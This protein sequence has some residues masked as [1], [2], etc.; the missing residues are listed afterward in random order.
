[1]VTKFLDEFTPWMVDMITNHSNIILMGSFNIHIGDED[2]AEGI[3][4]LDTIE[5]LSLEQWVDKP[6]HRSDNILDL[7]VSGAE[8][9]TKPVRCATGGLISD[10]LTIHFTLELKQSIF[11]RKK[12]ITYHKLK[13][14]N[15]FALDLAEMD[16]KGDDLDSI[17]SEFETKLKQTLDKHAPEVTKKITERKRQPWFDDNIKNLK[18][19]MHRR[20]KVWRKYK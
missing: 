4:F 13:K 7:V 18:R 16:L 9:K 2:A 19:N 15:M 5:A 14:T 20:E 10:H 11:M 3:T 12:E 6:T 1:M 8:G 17:I